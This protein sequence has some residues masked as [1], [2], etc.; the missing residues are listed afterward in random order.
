MIDDPKTSS[1]VGEAA[2]RLRDRAGDAAEGIKG[3][4][5]QASSTA[6]G[7]GDKAAG[8]LGDAKES[9]KTM[10]SDAGAKANDAFEDQKAAGAKRIKGISGAIRRAADELEGELPPAAT[11]IRRAADEIDAMTD[12][13]QRR[14]VRQILTDVQGFARR[15]PAAFLG[16]T[17]LGGFAVMRLLRTPTVPHEA[18]GDVHAS[19]A[20]R[21]LVAAD[22]VAGS[23]FPLDRASI[24]GGSGDPGGIAPEAPGFK[25]TTGDAGR[26]MGT[27]FGTSQP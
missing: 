20:G 23:P 12:A 10:A 3:V 5:A 7:M 6:Q 24:K 15:Q 9:A 21:S 25:T 1:I 4:G 19:G 17:V 11:Y 18:A 14:D 22:S 13:V 2:E 16:A 27:G 26:G 8:L